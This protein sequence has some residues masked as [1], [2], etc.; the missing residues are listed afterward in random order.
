[1]LGFVEA[2]GPISV[3]TFAKS[4]DSAWVEDALEATGRASIRRRGFPAELAVLLVIGMALFADRSIDD[5]VNHLGL[6]LPAKK[7]LA[8]SA[9]PQARS[10]L[11]SEP[12]KLL[13]RKA[14]AVWREAL[15]AKTWRGL[16]VFAVDGSCLK[17]QDSDDNYQAFGKPT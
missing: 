12:I 1:M 2:V 3:E 10:R 17:V 13:F 15:G 5:V 11:G 14:S 7:K 6:V 9:I 4:I 8:R 16:S